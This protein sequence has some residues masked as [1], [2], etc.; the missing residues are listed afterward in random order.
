VRVAITGSHGLIGSALAESLR[1]DGHDVVALA[2]DHLDERALQG[3]DAVVHLAGEP[4]AAKRWSDEQ[5]QRIVDSRSRTTAQL[6]SAIANMSDPPR[7][8]ISGSAVGYYGDRS[9]EILHEDSAAGDDFLA[10]V[11][12]AW[13]AATAPAT[14]AG[15]R[16]A[17]IRTGL[18]LTRTGGALAKM[19]PLFRLGLGGRFGSGRQ[20]WSWISLDD[21]VGAIR[22][23]LDHD[24]AGPVNVT[25]PA[26]VT[27]GEFAKALG[28][29]LH[30]P[31]VLP[32]PRFGPRLLLGAE[33]AQQLLFSSQRAEPAVLSANGYRFRHPDVDSAMRDA[34]A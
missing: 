13:E 21:E 22:F 20:W 31:A 18:V 26:P 3:Q 17:H 2:R 7:V 27:N 32:V 14:A 4:I 30:R 12:I 24:V 10:G 9:D 16:V 19:L 23:L 6:A 33:L 28:H 5:K 29:V 1:H 15:V 25:G 11:C 34:L 8:F